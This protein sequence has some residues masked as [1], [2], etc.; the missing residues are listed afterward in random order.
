MHLV[1]EQIKSQDAPNKSFCNDV[2]RELLKNQ[3]ITWPFIEP[4]DPVKFAIPDYFDIIKTPMDLSTVKR[5][6]YSGLYTIDEQF[7]ADVRLIISNC[8]T[9][10]LPN[11]AIVSLCQDFENLFNSKWSQKPTSFAQA[12]LRNF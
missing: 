10:N 6:L 9:Y 8:Y 11:S 1:K 3:T 12:D 2:L 5:K 7:E 4:V